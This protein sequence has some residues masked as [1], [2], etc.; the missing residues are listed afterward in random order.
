MTKEESAD[1][2]C[3][4]DYEPDDD[5]N[6]ADSAGADQPCEDEE[7]LNPKD[8][9]LVASISF[10]T[11][12]QSGSSDQLVEIHDDETSRHLACFKQGDTRVYVR[13]SSLVWY[14]SS[15]KNRISTDRVYRYADNKQHEG[16]LNVGDFAIFDYK[17]K[18]Q[19]VQVISFKFT[20]GKRF[21]GDSYFMK[22]NDTRGVE[23]LCYFLENQ[24]GKLIDV[25]HLQ[26]RYVNVKNFKRVVSLK[27][28]IESAELMLLSVPTKSGD[29]QDVNESISESSD[30]EQES[31][32]F[33]A[34]KSL[35]LDTNDQNEQNDGRQPSGSGS[36][37][38]TRTTAGQPFR[39]L[40]R[41]NYDGHIE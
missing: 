26:P 22:K 13:K 41:F 18:E 37:R 40:F 27:R 25:D 29:Q 15:T 36:R 35:Q 7:P 5:S 3:D 14:L 8:E 20:D 28:N 30:A 1:M 2:R 32:V 24:D 33:T 17:N 34:N 21:Y 39:S 31:E 38:S 19:F 10:L 4:P 11:A 6:Q 23:A 9:A 16:H 12:P